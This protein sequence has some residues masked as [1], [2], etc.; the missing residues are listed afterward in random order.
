MNKQLWTLYKESE[1]GKKCI[2]M[3]DPDKEDVY[4]VANTIFE[5][6]Y[7]TDSCS[8]V[9]N[10][11]AQFDVF[12]NNFCNSEFIERLNSGTRDDF[13]YV[14]ENYELRDSLLGEDDSIEL[15]DIIIAKNKLREKVA[16]VQAMSVFLYIHFNA[17]RPMLFSSRFDVIQKNCD[18]LGIELPPIPRTKDY[19]EYLLYYYDICAVWN[20]FQEENGL[21]DAEC[22]ACIYDFS[23]MLQETNSVAALPKPTNVWITGAGKGDFKS[24]D[25]LVGK[26]Y[27]DN[28]QIWACN[29]RTRRGDIIVMYCLSPRSYI[30]SIWRANSGG[31]FNPFDY[32]HCRT[33]VTDGVAMP[34]ITFNDLKAD[35]YFSQVP[36]VR[37]NLQGI[38]GV[39]LSAK[40]YSELIRMITDKGGT[41]S[42]YPKLFESG[43]LDFG[44]IKIE[45]DVEEKILIPTLKRLGYEECNWARQLS[46]K[47]GRSLKAI[48]DFVFFPKG[49]KHFASAPLVI[50]AKLDMSTAIE[51]RNAFSQCLS[52]ARMLRSSLMAICDKERLIVYQVDSNG[53]ANINAPVF[54]NHWASIYGDMEVGSQLNQL[55]GKEIVQ[56]LQY[57]K[58]SK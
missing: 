29:E 44:E 53:T 40:D 14:M 23:T 58:Q 18:N 30:H 22:C 11:L 34:L 48:P 12:Y 32:F 38:N 26:G 9:K 20:E 31:Q 4:E 45:K 6:S 56:S 57:S 51:L 17:F 36:I 47:A 10:C 39:Q 21:S 43:N 16:L 54:E 1:R 42:D 3:F 24:L 25:E 8:V 2:E 37:K 52:Y 28:D 41:Q 19:K 5:Y 7:K 55:I 49:E 46:Q 13:A 33:T 27:T 35:A 50:E 15:G